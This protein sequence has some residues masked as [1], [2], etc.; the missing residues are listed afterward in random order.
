MKGH[1]KVEGLVLPTLAK[2]PGIKVDLTRNEDDWENWSFDGFLTEIRKWLK[3]N[4][5]DD[6]WEKCREEKRT[7][8]SRHR[9][10]FMTT[11]E[12]WP[13]CFYCRKKHW[14][15][16]CDTVVDK[17]E[18]KEILRR[19]GACFKCGGNRLMK[20][21]MKR[22]CFVCQGKYHSSLHEE[23]DQEPEEY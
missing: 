1:T 20:N 16:H 6:D 17:K 22:S 12:R 19:K 2:L 14:P 23:R 10:A 21:C 5:N 8:Y 9:G 3:R 13:R 4:E 15:D 7:E 11:E 18:R